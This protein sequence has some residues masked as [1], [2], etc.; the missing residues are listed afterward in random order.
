[1]IVGIIT[2]M[3]GI[4]SLGQAKRTNKL[5]P[6]RG[7]NQRS[8]GFRLG[9]KARD[10]ELAFKGGVTLPDM[11]N[12]N[13]DPRLNDP[14]L[15]NPEPPR[16]GR[17]RGGGA[18]AW[19]WIW[20]LVL[21]CAFIWFAGWGWGS[22]G[23]WWWGTRG[24]GPAYAGRTYNSGA[25]GQ[26]NKS[27]NNQ[28]AVPAGEQSNGQPAENAGQQNGSAHAAILQ[29]SNKREFEGQSLELSDTPVL[30]KVSKDVFW[31]G[32]NKA[33]PLLVV[34]SAQA[35]APANVNQGESVN[36]TGT[37]E[38]AP[39]ATEAKNW[40]LDNAGIQRLEKEGA[41]VNASQATKT[42]QP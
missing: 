25:N 34:I 1:V 27:M 4:L 21:F 37:V 26:A 13:Q 33:A 42:Q 15:Q 38:K 18:W 5:Q 23:G 28:G 24:N 40:G 29:A 2:T 22:Y 19:W 30:Q 20:F 36:V 12:F 6:E 11:N 8:S 14:R 17:Y 9:R 7:L 10:K 16:Y 3:P 32:Q 35:P 31:I 39:P 41:Y